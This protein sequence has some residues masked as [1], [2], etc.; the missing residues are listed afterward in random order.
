MLPVNSLAIV[1]EVAAV[2]LSACVCLENPKISL[3]RPMLI[4]RFGG[5]PAR[6]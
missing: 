3:G 2:A 6:G 4:L 5:R 1:R